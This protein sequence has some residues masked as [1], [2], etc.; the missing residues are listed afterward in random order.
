VSTGETYVQRKEREELSL[1]SI[2]LWGKKYYWQ[3]VIEQGI[4]IGGANEEGKPV[5]LFVKP[6]KENIKE[7]MIKQ[8][9]NAKH[10]GDE[11]VKQHGDKNGLTKE[12]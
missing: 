3:K 4:W 12:T 6:S 10:I 5:N 2:E 1:L 8:I 9:A 11:L 7:F